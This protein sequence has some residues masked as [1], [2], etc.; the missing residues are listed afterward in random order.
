MFYCEEF[1][2][3]HQNIIG[4][5]FDNKTLD[6]IIN[7]INKIKIYSNCIDYGI[8]LEYDLTDFLNYIPATNVSDRTD[9]IH[10][11]S[12]FLNWLSAFY[13]WKSSLSKEIKEPFEEIQTRFRSQENQIY[14]LVDEIRNYSAHRGFAINKRIFDFISEKSSYYIC[15]KELLLFLDNKKSNGNKIN[16][17]FYDFIKRKVYDEEDIEAYELTSNFKKTYLQMH[18]ELWNRIKNDIHNDL[19]KIFSILP[20][21]FSNVY[22]ISIVSNDQLT[23]IN[24]GHILCQFLEKIETRYNDAIPDIY[25][26][27]FKS[28]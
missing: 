20:P 2:I 27:K 4:V 10:L 22:N 5:D 8:L 23:H 1:R 3:G 9:F 14:R 15:S 11:N 26:G 16:A 21:G 28:H 13:L 7:C 17:K 25:A 19:I 12:K 18:D 24:I 6:S